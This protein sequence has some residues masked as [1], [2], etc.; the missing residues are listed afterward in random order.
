MTTNSP[1]FEGIAIGSPP[2]IGYRRSPVWDRPA[3]YL[4]FNNA[5]RPAWRTP[6]GVIARG[7]APLMSV[8]KNRNPW[9]PSLP[10]NQIWFPSDSRPAILT[11]NPGR[12]T[13]FDSPGPTKY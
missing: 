11:L 6:A 8:R 4:L 9:D 5:E 2:W 3:R 1:P 13:R 7:F 12:E 10:L